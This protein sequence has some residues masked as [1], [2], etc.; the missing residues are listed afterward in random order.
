MECSVLLIPPI[1]MCVTH[2]II[3]YIIK[4]LYEAHNYHYRY[5]CITN[6]PCYTIIVHTLT[7]QVSQQLQLVQLKIEKFLHM[8]QFVVFPRVLH[9]L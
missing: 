6:L 1:N 7:I 8:W 5:I 9:P 3:P 4:S 2:L